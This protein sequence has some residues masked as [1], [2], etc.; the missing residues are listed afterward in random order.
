MKLNTEQHRKDL[1][2]KNTES[3]EEHRINCLT[4]NV[5]RY[6]YRL[7]SNHRRLS[8]FF[9]VN[10]APIVSGHDF[11]IERLPEKPRLSTIGAG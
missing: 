8:M 7:T 3:S 6:A 5:T 4:L 1:T 11:W 10:P 2:P 9:G